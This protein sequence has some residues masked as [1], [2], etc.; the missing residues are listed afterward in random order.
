M[1]SS[2]RTSKAFIII[3]CFLV[4][5]VAGC[6]SGPGSQGSKTATVVPSHESTASLTR[7]ETTHALNRVATDATA[8]FRVTGIDLSVTPTTIS[9]WACGSYIQVVYNAVFHVVSDPKGGTIVFSYTLNN[10]RSQTAE[11]LTINP[12]Q[13]LSNFVFTWQGSLPADHTYPGPGGVLVTS[14]NYL[15]SQMVYPTGGCR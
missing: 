12:G 14:P 4:I 8:T 1:L 10:G 5:W 13:H 11:K 15:Q 6:G 2:R 7:I 3:G 9:T